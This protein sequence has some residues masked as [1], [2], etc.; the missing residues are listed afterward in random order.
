MTFPATLYA[1]VRPYGNSV[2]KKIY[3]VRFDLGIDDRVTGYE[4]VEKYLGP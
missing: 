1:T 3:Q 4:V 2:A